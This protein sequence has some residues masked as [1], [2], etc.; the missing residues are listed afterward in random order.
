MIKN[1]FLCFIFLFSTFLEAKPWFYLQDAGETY[2]ILPV[3][4]R[5]AEE[6]I[7]FGVITAG[8]AN[9]IIHYSDLPKDKLFTLSDFGIEDIDSSWPREK[10]ISC[11]RIR[12]LVEQIDA[13]LFITG[14]A[15]ELQGQLLEECKRQKIKTIAYWDNFNAN[16]D[17]NY[18]KVA[19][20]VKEKADYLFV[21]SELVAKD[22]FSINIPT[23]IVGH[24][25]LEKWKDSLNLYKGIA[26]SPKKNE[27]HM[28]TYI[29]SY[30]A[31]YEKAFH[32]F[33]DILRE[34]EFEGV[35]MIQPH[36]RTDGSFER[37]TIEGW[38][39][40]HIDLQV[41]EEVSTYALVSLSDY[42]VCYNSSVGIQALA[43]GKRV[44]YVIPPNDNYS[45]AAIE[46]DVAP[47]ICSLEDWKNNLHNSKKI[48]DLF[49]VMG[50]PRDS[51]STFV[52]EIH[53]FIDV[54]ELTENKE[55][56]L[57]N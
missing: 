6:K 27:A 15:F 46:N 17:N 20:A 35:V 43:A 24:P 28:M 36:P 39:K 50:M 16:G 33:L 42:I 22:L 32:F 1:L 56:D 34:S 45:N 3:I 5:L 41:M 47:I 13:E 21:P 29:G 52:R 18:F 51:I 40:D 23:I 12:N 19:H 8:T 14:V 49:S 53:R 4:E 10:K 38:E 26:S 31:G 54:H 9:K 2:A 55:G 11:R 48:S 25:S 7:P 57:S 30:G 44:L 37:K